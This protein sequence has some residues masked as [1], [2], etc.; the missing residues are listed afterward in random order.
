MD[1]NHI[2]LTSGIIRGSD[3]HVGYPH[4]EWQCIILYVDINLYH[5]T[6][7]PLKTTRTSTDINGPLSIARPNWEAYPTIIN[8][9]LI[10]QHA[11]F[12]EYRSE[13]LNNTK[14]VSDGEQIIF[15][16]IFPR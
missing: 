7:I 12:M 1:V 16:V 13:A 5:N 6:N 9:S 11:Y 14:H 3:S 8:I 2:H 4:I 15:C 10:I